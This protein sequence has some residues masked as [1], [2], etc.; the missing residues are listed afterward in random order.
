MSE[1]R[2]LY[3]HRIKLKELLDQGLK[4]GRISEILCFSDTCIKQEYRRGGGKRNYCPDSAQEESNRRKR[5]GAGFT[6]SEISGDVLDGIKDKLSK[7]WAITR[8][9]IHFKMGHYRLQRA[10]AIIEGDAEKKT[11]TFEQRLQALE[12]QVEILVDLA[13]GAQ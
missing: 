4:T 3:E 7:G 1:K 12:S 10:L 13:R 5:I 9:R 8:I 2:F 11:L 6:K